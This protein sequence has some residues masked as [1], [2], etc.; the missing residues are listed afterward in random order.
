MWTL[1]PEVNRR[2]VVRWLATLAAR[3]SAGTAGGAPSKT[4]AAS[5][6]SSSEQAL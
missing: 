4:S 3:R 5:T 6:G 2:L 1:L